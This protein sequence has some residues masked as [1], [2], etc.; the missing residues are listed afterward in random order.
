MEKTRRESLKKMALASFLF[1]SVTL[2]VFIWAY[3]VLDLDT[4]SPDFYR[5]ATPARAYDYRE[6]LS[7][8]AGD[9]HDH[10]RTGGSGNNA[11]NQ[12]ATPTPALTPAATTDWDAV[13]DDQ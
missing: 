4:A 8:S 2:I 1:C 11:E 5:Q 6:F 3:G 13:E 12:A 9:E 10:G 7:D